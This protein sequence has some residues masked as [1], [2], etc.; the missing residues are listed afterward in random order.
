MDELKRIIGASIPVVLLGTVVILGLLTYVPQKVIRAEGFAKVAEEVITVFPQGWAFFTKPPTSSSFS[1]YAPGEDGYAPA[2]VPDK[3]GWHDAF[4]LNRSYRNAQAEFE[5]LEQ[6]LS[7]EELDSCAD[8]DASRCFAEL[9]AAPSVVLASPFA[10][11]K[12]CGVLEV[13]EETP[14]PWL[15]RSYTDESHRTV[16]V[17]RVQVDC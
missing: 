8:G 15:W 10:N 7:E 6:V 4:G 17:A 1:V 5:M 16:G 9:D 2:F 14:T 13:A 11:P 3:P 12:L